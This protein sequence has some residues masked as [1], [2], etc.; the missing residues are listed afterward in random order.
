M[1]LG[2]K[3][4]LIGGG[5][6]S[7]TPTLA[8][9]LFL[10]GSLRGSHL[11]LVDINQESA[12]KMKKY[13]H[14]MMD[15]LDAGWTVTTDRL[16]EA[17]KGA[18]VVC[19]SI[20][21]GGLDAM[22][23]DYTIPEKY[24]TYHTVG[25]TVGPGGISRTLRNVPVFLSIAKKMEEFCPN[26]WFIHVT[27]PLSQLTRAVAKETSIKVIG[28]CHNF[29]GTVSMLADYFGVD[30][31]DI[32]AVS[33]GVNH[34][35]YMKNITCKGNPVDGQLSLD[36]Y[37]KYHQNKTGELVTNTTD[38]LINKHL[39][40]QNNMEYY[41]N[42]FLFEKL[43]VFPVGSSNHVAENLPFYCNNLET[44][45]KYHIRRK[46]VLPRRQNLLN[47]SKEKIERMLN[48]ELPLPK[49]QLSNEGLSLICETLLTGKPSRTIVTMPNK[50]QI[51]NLPLDAAVE[52]WAMISGNGI[53]PI[54]SGE[55]PG[56]VSG[57]MLTIVNEQE[58]TVEAAITGDRK[59]L[60][61]ALHVSPQVQNKDIVEEL[62]NELL[63][64]NKEY[65]PQFFDKELFI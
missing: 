55:V 9:D 44:L 40:L 29:S 2:L 24:R 43:G 65:L 56:N 13:C 48:G 20:S 63:E 38:D 45:K 52:T 18:D 47:Q 37:I 10:R 23:K 8:G 39:G 30:H 21:T 60:Y 1:I 14:L 61:Q 26:A 46:G 54:L 16:E 15:H 11:S 53:H 49:I 59:L 4:V 5:S 6:F 17:L 19:A 62:G 35:T 57:S 41:L 51:S 33:V 42:F 32:D 12:E 7:W 50:G 22:H 34:Y 31:S 36:N 25:D 64:A 3:V 28:L 27:N 58:L